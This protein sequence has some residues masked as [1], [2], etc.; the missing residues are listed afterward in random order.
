MSEQ[1]EAAQIRRILVAVDASPS[2]E[3]GLEAAARIAER[4]GAE[5]RA[6]FVEDRELV[7]AAGHGLTREIREVSGRI[8]RFEREELERHLQQRADRIDRLIERRLRAT[9]MTY[10]LEVVRGEVSSEILRR[11]EEADLVTLGG[12]GHSPWVTARIGSVAR[13]LLE[14]C[15]RP[16][17]FSG[18]KSRIGPHVM[19]VY[20]DTSAGETALRT[21]AQIADREE[22]Y[23][24]RIVV[25]E[26]EQNR[27]E[28]RRAEVRQT[29]PSVQ[30]PLLFD[31]FGTLPAAHLA[32]LTRTARCGLL[33]LPADFLQEPAAELGT[34][35]RD[36]R[37]P[38][39]VV[40]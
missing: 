8:G 13:R 36:L 5:I 4:L 29:I 26:P 2:S 23:P 38:I 39:M 35:I 27:R 28:A 14:E 31:E 19:V 22:D 7:R 18:E 3:R 6:L 17:L 20:A 32:R 37:C 15:T 16:L 34:L 9:Q 33:V 1:T 24:L 10:R 12:R 21:A 25:I 40:P 11:S 30:S